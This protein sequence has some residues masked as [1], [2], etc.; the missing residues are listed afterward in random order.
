[1]PT[2]NPINTQKVYNIVHL[3]NKFITLFSNKNHQISPYKNNQ[4]FILFQHKY[5]PHKLL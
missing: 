5:I 3:I 2:H 1:M 4:I